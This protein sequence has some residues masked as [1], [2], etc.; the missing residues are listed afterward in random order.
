MAEGRATTLLEFAIV[1]S[2]AV[3]PVLLLVLLVVGVV[4]PLDPAGPTV[5]NGDRHVSVRQVAALKTFE[6][7]IVRRDTVKVGLPT[8]GLL[9]DGVPQCRGTWSGHG[10]VLDRIRGALTR[11]GA[12]APSPAQR[13]AAQLAD[14]DD[15]L[16]RFST[17]ANRRVSG[18]VGFDAL[19]WFEAVGDAL[20]LP[21][22]APDYPGRK[23]TVQCADIASAR[24][25]G[26]LR[27]SPG[28]APKWRG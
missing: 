25:D 26:C 6:R 18:A 3:V 1:A 10:R 27:R 20:R 14:L 12:A 19:R 11:P 2:A 5:R 9:L 23:F 15:E 13:L 16:Q 8:A 22:E 4:R 17:G 7:A 21:V 28:A 24:M